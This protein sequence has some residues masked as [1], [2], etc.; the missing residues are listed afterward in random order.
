M[1]KI[2][3]LESITDKPTSA[4]VIVEKRVS[5]AGSRL[6]LLLAVIS[7]LL[8]LTVGADYLLATQTKSAADAELQKQQEIAKQLEA[9]IKEQAELD[10]KIKDMDD[11]INAIKKLRTDQTGPSRVL[12]ALRERISSSPGLYLES[13][14][15]KGEQLTI[16]GNSPNEYTVSGFGRS[17]EFSGGLFSNLSIST[18]LKPVQANQA[19]DQRGNPA[20][21]GANPDRPAPETVNFTIKCAYKPSSGSTMV[22]P[23]G[24]KSGSVPGAPNS[25]ATTAAT[26]PAPNQPSQMAKN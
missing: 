9:V 12:E 17:L 11:R 7:G 23:D 22:L 25:P 20:Q 14:E 1:I 16:M 13:V 4:A 24:S 21:I 2:N 15:Q 8:L 5:N 10:K 26:M 18:E 6:Y 19:Q 3:L